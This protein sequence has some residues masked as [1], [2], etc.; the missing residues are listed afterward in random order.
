ML[1]DGCEVTKQYKGKDVRQVTEL[2]Y[3]LSAEVAA[4]AVT[5]PA[6]GTTT[7]TAS[8][9]L[10]DADK[11]YLNENFE[12]GSF[13]E[14]FITLTPAAGGGA[15]L[16]VP[17]MGFYGDWTS[18]PIVDQGFYRDDL[19]GGENWAQA[20]TNTAGLNSLENTISFY[21]GDNPYHDGVTYLDERNAISPNGD[22]YSDA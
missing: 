4:S 22:D 13:V 18:A 21:L 7:V 10:T 6:G 9:T 5:V 3:E 20:Y 19:N 16:S 2:P 1:T 8:V 11:A 17:Y 15:V 14:G 12:N